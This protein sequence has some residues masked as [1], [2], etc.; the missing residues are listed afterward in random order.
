MNST[1][2][3]S[4]SV[5]DS[6]WSQYWSKLDYAA[7]ENASCIPIAKDYTRLG[8]MDTWILTM[9]KSCENG[10]PHTRAADIIAIPEGFPKDYLPK[11]LE[12]EKIH[13]NQRVDL[14]LWKK[15]YKKYWNYEIFSSPPQN[16]PP[17][18][19]TMIRANPDTCSVPYSCWNNIW[20]SVPVYKSVTNL[21]F[22]SC[23][24]LWWNQL[25]NKIYNNPPDEWVN[26]FGDHVSQ[27]E[28]PHEISA[29]YIA[30]WIYNKNKNSKGIQILMKFWD[31]NKEKLIL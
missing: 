21:N 5:P 26:F 14:D 24:V 20:W 8:T 6:D 13:L 16:F 29:V 25:D 4:L 28:H 27:S 19:I 2:I 7:R 1:N 31:L 3:I 17:N 11:T 30:D 10:M 15:F 23:P 22:R 18:L 12:H 9:P